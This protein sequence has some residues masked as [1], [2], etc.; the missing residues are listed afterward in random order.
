MIRFPFIAPNRKEVIVYKTCTTNGTINEFFLRPIWIYPELITKYVRPH[1]P[2]FLSFDDF[3]VHQRF[4]LVNT[5]LKQLPYIPMLK[6]GLAAIIG[7][8]LQS[9]GDL[10]YLN[11]L[12]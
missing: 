6:T 8:P 7:Q 2:H 4:T 9:P 1:F 5:F 10:S 12:N 11:C 3:I